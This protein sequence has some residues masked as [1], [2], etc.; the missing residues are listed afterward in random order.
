MQENEIIINADGN[1]TVCGAL[2]HKFY[3][4]NKCN[5]PASMR[6]HSNPNTVFVVEVDGTLR[7]AQS[8]AEGAARYMNNSRIL[9]T[10]EPRVDAS[11]FTYRPKFKDWNLNLTGMYAG[12]CKAKFGAAMSGEESDD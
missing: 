11:G 7:A 8:T 5:V 10:R 4:A 2:A 6:D 9:I 3:F 1:L 12:I